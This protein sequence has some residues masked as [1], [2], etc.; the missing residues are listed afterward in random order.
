MKS[1]QILV[2][3]FVASGHADDLSLVADVTQ[4]I[5]GGEAAAIMEFPGFVQNWACGG[6]LVAKDMVLTA[7][8]CREYFVTGE[9]VLVGSFRYDR[10][11]SGS[12][13]RTILSD[14][15]VHPEFDDTHNFNDFM[16]FRIQPVENEQLIPYAL[17]DNPNNPSTGDTLTVIG[18]GYTE[19][20]GDRPYRLQKLDVSYYSDS[21]C[22]SIYGSYVD[23]GLS[24]CA[25]DPNGGKDACQGDSGGPIFDQAGVLVGLVSWGV[26]CALPRYPGVVSGMDGATQNICERTLTFCVSSTDLSFSMLVSR[27]E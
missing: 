9:D 14:M 13:Y 23:T 6:A 15:I 20:D 19:Y 27:R 25:G 10:Q 18:V 16:L 8:H 4:Q 24:F 21:A 11:S 22:N 17:N 3:L 5:V 2:G 12:E 1:L 26:K 7:A